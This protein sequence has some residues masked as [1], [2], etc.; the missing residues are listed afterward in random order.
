[1]NSI[2]KTLSSKW[3]EY[4]VEIFVIV[5][6]ILAAYQLDQWRQQRKDNSERDR[7][8]ENLQYEFS[9][10][11]E[12]I[13]A[14]LEIMDR[15]ITASIGI[16]EMTGGAY[17]Q[18]TR[19][20]V[21]ELIFHM[22][23]YE[24]SIDLS[25]GAYLDLLN[26]G[27]LNLVNEDSLR[28][29]LLTWSGGLDRITYAEDILLQ[30]QTELL[31]PYLYKWYS[32]KNMDINYSPYFKGIPRSRIPDDLSFLDDLE[33]ENLVDDHLYRIRYL[34]EKYSELKMETEIILTLL[35]NQ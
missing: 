27:K 10:N 14:E 16:F 33:F 23:T 6:G 25:S 21:D 26:S 31:L 28:R 2:R 15:S 12:K 35:K 18:Y 24:P 13:N 34:H 5:I 22:I 20:E 30:L 4:L 19:E 9:I 32:F 3:P 7:L 11:L 8:L 17:K 29:K 1:M